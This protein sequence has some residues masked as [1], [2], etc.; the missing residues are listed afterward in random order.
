[1]RAHGISDF[2]DPDS[3]GNLRVQM[4]PGSDLD[5]NSARNKAAQ[6]ACK[7]LE[8]PGSPQEQAKARGLALQYSKCMRD[9]GIKDFPDPD[10]QGGIDVAATPG[11]DLDPNNPLN[12][13]ADKACSH[14][15]GGNGGSGASLQPGGKS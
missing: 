10:S 11:S 2:P 8:P 14:L 13:A 4:Q 9:H 5:P 7:A 1:M 3:H 15:R 12:K 6:Q